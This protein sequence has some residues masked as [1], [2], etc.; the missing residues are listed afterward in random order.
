MSEKNLCFSITKAKNEKVDAIGC[1][2][3]KNFPCLENQN[4]RGFYQPFAKFF[5]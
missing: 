5:R 3:I 4:F 1:N 2:L